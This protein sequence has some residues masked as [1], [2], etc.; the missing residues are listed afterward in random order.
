VKSNF[1]T[2]HCK[3]DKALYGLKQAPRAWYSHL[4]DK[5]KS[6]GFMTSQANISLFHYRR[7]SIV[8]FLL[9]YVDD[10]IVTSS[11]SAA[12]LALLRDLLGDFALKDLSPLHYFLGIEV[13]GLSDGI[14][15]TQSKYT[16]DL[17][18]RA[19]MMSCKAATT[20]LSSTNKLSTDEGDRLGLDASR[21]RRLVG[22][23][24]YLTLT[25]PDISFSVNKVCHYIHAPTTVHL[26]AVKM[27]L[28]FLKHT[29]GMGFNIR[30]S[31]STMVS[32]FSDAYWAGRTDDR[33]ST[34]WFAVF[35]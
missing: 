2:Y 3:L 31:S 26:T 34:G 13:Q 24:Q 25:C 28:H 23:L 19:G 27:I 14:C 15:L 5:L 11:S 10:I 32:A 9:V 21:Y 17:L 16:R 8:I 4:S 6:F 22:A 7:G 1:L 33:K 30:Q 18:H 12:V 20:P 29:L 35:S